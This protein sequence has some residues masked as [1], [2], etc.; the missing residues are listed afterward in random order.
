MKIRARKLAALMMASALTFSL[1]ACGGTDGQEEKKADTASSGTQEGSENKENPEKEEESKT[2]ASG[3]VKKLVMTFP[4][5]TGAPADTQKVQDAVNKITREKL[6]IEVEFQ[7]TDFG[8][9]NQ[10]VTLALSGGEQVD[11]LACTGFPYSTGVQQGYFM[12]LEED[13]LLATYGQGIIDTMGMD[14]IDACRYG[15]VLYGLP[16]NRDIASGH[17]CLVVATEYLD[18]I[19]YEVSGDEEIH[20][21]TLDEMKALLA[22]LH[23]KYPDKETFRPTAGSSSQF[24][25][26][27][28]LGGNAFGVLLDEGQNTDVVNLYENDT[29]MD[30]CKMIYEFNQAGY[31]G[32]DAATDSTAVGDLVKAGRLIS[33][34]T[35]G[36]PG[37]KAQES[38]LCGRDVTVFQTGNDYISSTSVSAYPWC[39]PIST[40]DAAAAMTLLNE[41]YTNAELA[42]LLGWGIEGVHYIVQDNGQINYPEGLDASTSGWNHSMGWMMPN[43]FLTHVWEGDD[44][45]VWKKMQEFNDNAVKSLASGFSFDSTNVSNEMTAVAN[46]YSEY[47]VS[48]E[49]GFLNPEEAVPEMVEKMKNAGLEKIIE[50]KTNQFKEWNETK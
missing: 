33:Y 44:P 50:E 16:N 35:G 39:I 28:P 47:S 25:N 41:F 36:K 5:W 26:Y 31:I 46:V 30:Y 18:G 6:G 43:Q 4:T 24:M 19:G 13:D 37:I 42:N 10:S 14:M 22:E 49:F 15:G 32:K 34:P 27:D 7:I 45:E 8:S 48:V 9:Y 12:D 38:G 17:G 1:T 23:D 3:E 11:I 40:A 2:E 20:K 21:I 29:Y